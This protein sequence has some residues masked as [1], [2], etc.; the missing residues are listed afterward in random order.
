MA[1]PFVVESK[2][3]ARVT[4]AVNAR[5]AFTPSECGRARRHSQRFRLL[6]PKWHRPECMLDIGDDQLLMLLLVIQPKFNERRRLPQGMLKIL[7]HCLV[8]P[9][10]VGLDLVES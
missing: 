5:F 1:W 9:F 2:S 6:R 4:N 7:L 3:V 8:N 10:P